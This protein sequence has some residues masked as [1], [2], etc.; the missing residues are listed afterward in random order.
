[1][2]RP[3]FTFRHRAL[4]EQRTGTGVSA[5]QYAAPVELKCRVNLKTTLE[6]PG[7]TAHRAGGSI[8]LPAG[9]GARPGDRIT[10]EGR[11]YMLASALSARD[12]LGRE[13]HIEGEL[14]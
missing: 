3:D 11:Q 8:L 14:I 1:M 9:C 5:A 10:F 2:L 13:S 4:W 6:G 12:F 7:S